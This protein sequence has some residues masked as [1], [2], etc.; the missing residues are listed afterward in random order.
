MID[1]QLTKFTLTQKPQQY[2]IRNANQSSEWNDSPFIVT[3]YIPGLTDERN[4][5]QSLE[6]NIFTV[7]G[8]IHWTDNPY[9]YLLTVM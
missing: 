8:K 7:V 3:Y 6:R 5:R 4:K 9:I 1:L 2:F